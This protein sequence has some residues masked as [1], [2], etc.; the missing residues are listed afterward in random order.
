MQAGYP[1]NARS[2]DDDVH[3]AVTYVAGITDRSA[4]ATAVERLGW[5]ADRLQ[6]AWTVSTDKSPG[7]RMII[8]DLRDRLLGAALDRLIGLG[9]P[10]TSR[11][12][13]DRDIR[14]PMPDGVTLGTDHY[15]PVEVTR[16][17]V[18]LIRT[19][20]DKSSLAG[21]AYGLALARRGLQAV[22]QDVRGTFSSEGEF[23]P[24][25]HETEDGIATVSW[26]RLQDCCDGRIGTAGTSYVGYTQWSIAPYVEPKLSAMALG[27]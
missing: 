16:G 25:H 20:N 22:V 19:P 6:Q 24:F 10:R 21:R 14:V 27:I 18:V 12:V 8:D 23:E 4:F 13:I 26:L 7:D 11:V 1:V 2:A 3:S 17:P 5:D 9:G 15:R